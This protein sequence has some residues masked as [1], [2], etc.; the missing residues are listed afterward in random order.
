MFKS[1][2]LARDLQTLSKRQLAQLRVLVQL[3]RAHLA[4]R[5][6]DCLLDRMVDLPC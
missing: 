5:H 3:S 6:V 4:R 1:H 2:V